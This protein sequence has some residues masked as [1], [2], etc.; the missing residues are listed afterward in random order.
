MIRLD[1]KLEQNWLEAQAK[2]NALVGI[3]L[4]KCLSLKRRAEACAVYIFPLNLYGIT[5]LLLLKARSLALQQ[6]LTRLL[7]TGRR[8][9][10]CR[11]VSIQRTRNGGLGIP[12]L[13]RIR[14]AKRLAYL[15]RSL[16]G[17]AVW[18]RKASRTFSR[19]K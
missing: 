19:F 3:W 10:I 13:E 11:Q 6:C 5:V 17:D 15:D 2:V 16:S 12:D 14:L 4:R 8:S 1:F 18:K 7:W 9:I